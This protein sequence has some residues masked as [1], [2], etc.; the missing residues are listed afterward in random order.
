MCGVFH[1]HVCA[2]VC[3]RVC[4]CV[5]ARGSVCVFCCARVLAR[6]LT[7]LC[8]PVWWH[9]SCV[10]VRICACMHVKVM[11]ST[12][13]PTSWGSAG[14]FNDQETSDFRI[15][16]SDG[17]HVFHVHSA[18]L[19]FH[20]GFFREMLRAGEKEALLSFTGVHP[21]CRAILGHEHSFVYVAAPQIWPGRNE[22]PVCL[23]NPRSASG[24]WRSC[25]ASSTVGTFVY[26]VWRRRKRSLFWLKSWW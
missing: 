15:S 22:T 8:P 13:H 12:S 18:I 4:V 21:H 6:I 26:R 16:V 7:Q 5:F 9:L 1:L 10:C 24:P 3:M 17:E 19:R 20:S 14:L 11:A 2:F 25:F 23:P